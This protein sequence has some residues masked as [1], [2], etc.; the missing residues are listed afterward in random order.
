MHDRTRADH[1][2]VNAIRVAVQRFAYVG[3]IMAAIGLMMLGKA[4][5]I[6]ME[7]VRMTLSDSVAP[8]LDTLARPADT[9]AGGMSSIDS[10]INLHEENARLRAENE[11]LLRWEAVAL[12]LE[13]ENQVLR[14]LLNY[15]PSP[16]ARSVSARVIADFGG[17]FA[18]SMLL[19]AGSRNGISKG[20]AVLSGEALV[21]RVIG[22]AARSARVLLVTDLNSRI[23]VMVAPEQTRAI[24]AGDNS[25]RPHLL[26][27]MPETAIAPGDRVV[28]SGDGG[29]FP[30]GLPVGVVSGI[31]ETSIDVRPYVD[32]SRLDVVRVVDFG[33]AAIVDMTETDAS[34]GGA[35]TPT[36][37]AP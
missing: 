20:A 8:I 35:G 29:V 11:R 23:P 13:Q 7:R 3:L 25:E 2:S 14:N 21:G 17:S 12:R 5:T 9:L 34:A 6:M 26:H 18:H 4:D 32:L 30:P 31:T 1:R 15:A 28:T 22:V 33:L 27:V 19:Y 16:E 36:T 10:W 37:A 24:L